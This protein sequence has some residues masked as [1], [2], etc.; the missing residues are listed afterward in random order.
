MTLPGPPTRPLPVAADKGAEHEGQADWER[1]SQQ[2]YLG[3]LILAGAHRLS[4]EATASL[5]NDLSGQAIFQATMPL[6]MFHIIS[7]VIR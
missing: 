3:L 2:A 7:R 6:K 5:W 4:K 1:S